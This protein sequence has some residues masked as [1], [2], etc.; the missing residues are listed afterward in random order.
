MLRFLFVFTCFVW[1]CLAELVSVPLFNGENLNG[2]KVPD[3]NIWW[4]VE[5]RELVCRSGPK[6]K[7]SILWSEK[8][9][10]N[11]IV[12]LD[13]KMV[14]G[15]VDSGLF[16]RNMDQIQ[17]GMSGSMKRDMTTSPYIPKKGLS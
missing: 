3:G 10:K 4:S 11:F 8:K 7:G 16:L 5:N 1:P 12:E 13:F 6:R 17:L 2:F 14:S 15:I 9:Y